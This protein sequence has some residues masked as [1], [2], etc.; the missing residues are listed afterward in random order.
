MVTDTAATRAPQAILKRAPGPRSPGCAAWPAAPPG[1]WARD[2]APA[3]AAAA[4]R[5]ARSAAAAPQR[6]EDI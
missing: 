1:C 5:P 6:Y 2:A 3:P 4:G